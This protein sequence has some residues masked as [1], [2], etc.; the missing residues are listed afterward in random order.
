MKQQQETA[1][2]LEMEQEDDARA[3][4]K[5]LEQSKSRA[6]YEARTRNKEKRRALTRAAIAAK[7]GETK[8]KAA[9]QVVFGLGKTRGDRRGLDINRVGTRD[10]H[11]TRQDEAKPD[12]GATRHTMTIDF[13]WSWC[14][15][16]PSAPRITFLF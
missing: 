9:Q 13:E 4:E 11:E 1:R 8:A 5:G 2:A 15:S 14:F 12:H 3:L 6:K 10:M 16:P 7:K